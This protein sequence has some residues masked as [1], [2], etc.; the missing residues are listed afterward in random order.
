M[1]NRAI[2]GLVEAELEKMPAFQVIKQKLDYFSIAE[3]YH[4]AEIDHLERYCF[5][6]FP[7]FG[8]SEGIYVDADFIPMDKERSKIHAATA[9]T[10]GTSLVDMKYMGE[11]AG[12]IT[13][14]MRQVEWKL[15]EEA[16]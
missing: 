4:E 6:A 11:L 14:A 15:P 13:Y 10:L 7:N 8:S 3:S 5:I 2:M 9:K 12:L 1:T 16:M